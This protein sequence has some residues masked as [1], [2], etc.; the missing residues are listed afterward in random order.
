MVA[1]KS[2]RVILG[3]DDIEAER[4]SV[5]GV[6]GRKER[7]EQIPGYSLDSSLRPRA[8]PHD[9]HESIREEY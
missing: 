1:S 7:K 3:G 9:E 6:G 2:V 8:H 4:R 5:L